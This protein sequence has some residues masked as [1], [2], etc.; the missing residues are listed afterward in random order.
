MWSFL[1]EETTRWQGLGLEP[2]T[3]SSEVQLANHDIPAPPHPRTPAPPHPR[4][5][6]KKYVEGNIR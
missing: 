2:P 5:P 1:S 6:V 4:T 3:F